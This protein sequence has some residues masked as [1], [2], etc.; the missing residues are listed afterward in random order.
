M[1]VADDKHFVYDAPE[2]NLKTRK[3]DDGAAADH[4]NKNSAGTLPLYKPKSD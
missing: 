4:D 3:G 2:G 1:N